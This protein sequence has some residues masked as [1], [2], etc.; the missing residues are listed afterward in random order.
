MKGQKAAS[1]GIILTI[2]SIVVSITIPEVRALLGLESKPELEDSSITSNKAIKVRD[3]ANQD[4]NKSIR[5]PTKRDEN[6]TIPG[7]YPF[8]STEYLSADKIAYYS[9]WDLRIMR[10]EIYA[11]HGYVF[12]KSKEIMEYFNSQNWY[13]DIPKVSSDDLFLFK[14]KFSEIERHNVEL[15]RKVETSKR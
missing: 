10:N 5:P 11:R 14:Y 1:L 13:W 4:L 12:N 2:I 3:E 15:I 6:N 7:K 8:T 9:S